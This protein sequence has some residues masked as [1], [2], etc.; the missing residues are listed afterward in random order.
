[1]DELEVIVTNLGNYAHMAYAATH[2]ATVEKHQ[3][4][5]TQ[6]VA[7]HAAAVCYLTAR[8]AMQRVAKLA[9][10]VACETRAVKTLG[11]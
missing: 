3:I 5:R 9:E 2:R 11:A 1:M 10:N 8:R 4:A 6:I 7:L